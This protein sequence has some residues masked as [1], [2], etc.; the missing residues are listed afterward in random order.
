MAAVDRVQERRRA[1]ALARHYRDQEGV[2][3]AEIARRLASIRHSQLDNRSHSRRERLDVRP[4]VLV[5]SE[6][7]GLGG[8]LVRKLD[9]RGIAGEAVTPG[10]DSEVTRVL[11][12]R[13]GAIAIVTREDVLA[14]R[15]TLLCAHVRP[16][17]PLWVTIFD[18]TLI[19]RL[20]QEMPSVNI[21][22][23]AELVACEVAD[24]CSAL[25]SE[26]SRWRQGVRIVDGALR[27]M[28]GAGAGLF[29]ALI[30][31]VVISMI[32][33]RENALNGI[34]FSTRAIATVAD[35]PASNTGPGWFKI[36]SAIN[37][38]AAL[39]LVAVFTAALVRRLR[40]PV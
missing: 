31:Q 37:I 21:V 7:D 13:W 10:P 3:I 8:A 29:G 22:S 27:L 30:V 19:H 32:A 4:R 1:A 34:Y 36:A 33:L 39:V 15:L 16:D 2:P 11:R 9:Q 17:I 38:I 28:V 25:T 5:L 6:P 20:R 14:L 40:S 24:H 18:T 35:A 26:A 23:S 12:D